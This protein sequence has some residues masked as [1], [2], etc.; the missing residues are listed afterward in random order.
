MPRSRGRS[1][2]RPSAPRP[3]SASPPKQN[4]ST[5]AAPPPAQHQ[6]APPPAMP[7]QGGGMMSGIGGMVAQGMALGTGSALA[8]RAID[9]VMGSRHPEPA[10]ATQAAE[11]IVREQQPCAQQAKAFSECM[12]FHEGTLDMCQEY[13]DKMRSCRLALQ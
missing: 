7:Q 2:P 11:E 10:E 4:Y 5:K 1:A 8:H 9:S 13:F 3:R 6:A 12:L